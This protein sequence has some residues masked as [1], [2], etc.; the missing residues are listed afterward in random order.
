MVNDI[1]GAQNVAMKGILVKTGKQKKFHDVMYVNNA[2]IPQVNT[3]REMKGRS[4]Q[5]HGQCVIVLH[6]Q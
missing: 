1:H 6:R 4:S 5:D 3:E 2:S